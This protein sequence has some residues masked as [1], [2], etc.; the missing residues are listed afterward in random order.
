MGVKGKQLF[1]TI[2]I[3]IRAVHESRAA[4]RCT[5]G[6]EMGIPVCLIRQPEADS[7]TNPGMSSD[8]KLHQ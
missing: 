7:K 6:T 2:C 5:V 4:V 8:G 3:E 1:K